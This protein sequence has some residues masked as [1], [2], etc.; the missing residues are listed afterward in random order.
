[1]SAVIKDSLSNRY[2]LYLS[3]FNNTS[4]YY[5]YYDVFIYIPQLQVKRELQTVCSAELEVPPSTI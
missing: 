5:C 4:V 3:K 1:M 2:I